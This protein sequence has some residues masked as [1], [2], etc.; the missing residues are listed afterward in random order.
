VGKGIVTI[1][2]AGPGSPDLITLRGLRA[3]HEA[4]VIVMDRLLPA[5]MLEELGVPLVGK[6]VLHRGADGGP[7][8]Q[9][10]V[11]L[12]MLWA[13]S[14]GRRVARLKGGD[15][16]VFGRG[17]EEMRFLEQH[18]VPCEAVPGISSAIAA[19][20]GAGLSL[21][22]RGRGRSF[23]VCTARRQG[24]GVNDALPRADSLVVLMGVET[25]EEVVARLQ[26]DG[27]PSGTPAAVIGRAWQ[28]WERRIYST[29]ERI[30]A[31]AREA[32]AG[33]PAVLVVGVAA[34][35][36]TGRPVILF[37]GLDPTAFRSLGDLL[38]W[39]ALR[40]IPEA[41]AAG[42]VRAAAAG[43]R[44]G[45][46]ACAVF[47]SKSGVTEFFR[48]VHDQGGDA[49]VLAG[50]RAIAAGGGTAQRLAEHGIR[51]DAVPAEGGCPGIL[52]EVGAV[53]GKGV[54]LVQGTHAPAALEDAL[55][56][57]GARVVRVAL[58]FVE[59]H[60][61]MGRPLPEHD[62]VFFVSPSGVRAFHGA[63]GDAGFGRDIWCIGR[64]TLAELHRLGFDGKVVDPHGELD[65]TT[66]LAPHRGAA[67]ARA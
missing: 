18:G 13:A 44:G 15:P 54:L 19:P 31:D 41:G 58:H 52:A 21:T 62:A 4:D 27:W 42:Q 1:I 23:A 34:N 49:R 24:G 30:S 43:L 37:T 47:T 22:Q 61:E 29:L 14:K 40:V 9:N 46:F 66:T 39:P 5:E 20:A 25:L 3:L 8:S 12:W 67:A 51:A 7:T 50:V 26:G 63:Y 17:E 65:A 53:D 35:R 56:E 45:I 60:P 33:P 6:T 28:P 2:G 57:R 32:H 64:A 10:A 48:H 55:T 59:P 16:F 36:R 11:N 38:H